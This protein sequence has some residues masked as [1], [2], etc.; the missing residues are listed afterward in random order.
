[1]T[2]VQYAS[3]GTVVDTAAVLALVYDHGPTFDLAIADIVRE[4]KQ[5]GLRL[6]GISQ[7]NLPREGR[8]RCDMMVEELSSGHRLKISEDR[9]SGAHGCRLDLSAMA[10]AVALVEQAL[11]TSVDLLVLNKF[12]KE[13]AEGRGFRN[14]MATSIERGIPVLVGVPQRNLAAFRAFCGGIAVE[15]EAASS[16]VSDWVDSNSL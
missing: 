12:G 11:E 15:R 9:G 6:A 3:S 1:M 8:V 4:L 7:T 16:T 5:R 2:N 14:S 10:E 13:E